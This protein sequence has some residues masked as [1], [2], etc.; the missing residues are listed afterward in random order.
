MHV[1]DPD[2]WFIL[3]LHRELLFILHTQKIK[4]VHICLKKVSYLERQSLVH[5]GEFSILSGPLLE[6]NCPCTPCIS[7]TPLHPLSFN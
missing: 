5:D 7:L 1:S 3:N 4:R 2:V 6:V